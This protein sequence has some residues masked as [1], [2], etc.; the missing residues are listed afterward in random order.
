M[1][2]KDILSNIEDYILSKNQSKI[3][4][5]VSSLTFTSING[6]SLLSATANETRQPESIPNDANIDPN[7]QIRHNGDL[8]SPEQRLLLCTTLQAVD[9][10]LNGRHISIVTET[11][12]D[13]LKIGQILSFLENL[14]ASVSRSD[15]VLNESLTDYLIESSMNYIMTQDSEGS[16]AIACLQLLVL[17]VC[18]LELFM[19]MNYTGPELLQADIALFSREN[20]SSHILSQLECDGTY[21]F[22]NTDI[23]ICLIIARSILSFLSQ[24]K[25]KCWRHGIFLDPSGKILLKSN[26]SDMGQIMDGIIT[27][28]IK[29]CSW[30]SARASVVHLRCLQKQNYSHIPTL[31]KECQ[32]NFNASF[33]EF[34]RDEYQ[35][36]DIIRPQLWVEWGLC[37]HFFEFGDKVSMRYPWYPCTVIDQ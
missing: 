11:T 2:L 17:G 25:F 14:Q 19:Q 22:P 15:G 33:Q 24:P 37:Y 20:L 23:P 26:D 36:S 10:L 18:Y 5:L 12:A 4:G 13:G 29:S 34:D 7:I 35:D 8:I 28:N 3:A 1:D 30:H 9:S 16:E 21:P 31:W 32:M 27:R 6:P